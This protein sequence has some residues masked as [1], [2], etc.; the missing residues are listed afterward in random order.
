MSFIQLTY[1]IDGKPMLV[2]TSNIDVFFTQDDQTYISLT[3]TQDSIKIQESLEQ[4]IALLGLPQ[5]QP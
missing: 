5:N 4:V 3:G 2:N 1:A